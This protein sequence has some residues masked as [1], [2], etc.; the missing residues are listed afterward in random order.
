MALFSNLI[1]PFD[2]SPA[3]EQA[4]MHAKRMAAKFGARIHVVH[5]MKLPYLIGVQADRP[6]R[7]T[8]AE[9]HAHIDARLQNLLGAMGLMAERHVDERPVEEWLDDYAS[10]LPAPLIVMSRHGW[11]QSKRGL[12]PHTRLVLRNSRVP[13]WLVAHEPAEVQNVLACV[14]LSDHSAALG[15]FAKDVAQAFGATLEL[16]HARMPVHE[17]GYLQ[18]VA[19]HNPIPDQEA[20]Y[21]AERARLADLAAALATAAFPVKTRFLLGPTD[22]V[23]GAEALKAHS[24]LIVCG[25]HARGALV[26]FLLGSTTE[27]IAGEADGHVLVVP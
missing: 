11:R 3:A 8:I 22:E 16:A 24:E 27:R 19:W 4:L 23:V 12:G 18:E 21:A 2:F 10:K 5:G 6:Q 7:E 26:R 14:D 13:V 20:I 17:S 25:K 1:V 9:L 15:A